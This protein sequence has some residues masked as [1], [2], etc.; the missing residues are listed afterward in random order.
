MTYIIFT[1]SAVLLVI[2]T[3]IIESANSFTL[4]A[5]G[6]CCLIAVKTSY[7]SVGNPHF[8]SLIHP[9]DPGTASMM[10]IIGAAMYVLMMSI[11]VS[12]L[13]IKIEI[14]YV[15]LMFLLCPG[16]RFVLR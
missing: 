11:A 3:I 1:L 5:S 15:N 2:W 14:L 6:F 13:L 12:Y 16:F 7:H 8:V 10:T 4:I 9:M